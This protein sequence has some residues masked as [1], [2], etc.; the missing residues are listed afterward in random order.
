MKEKQD[1]VNQDGEKSGK[2]LSRRD[3]LKGAAAASAVGVATLG[4]GSCA[5]PPT[6]P[7][8][9][10]TPPEAPEGG[11]SV[12]SAES[13][14][15]MKWKFEEMP[16]EYP[17]PDSRISKTITHDVII[18]GSGM[19]GLCAAVA[20]KEDGADVRVIS[21]GK[22]A[23]SRG[24]SNHAIGSR[25]QKELGIDYGPDT[26]TGRHA[27]KVEK[28]SASCYVDERKWSTWINN[29]GKAMDWMIDKMATKGLKVCLEPGYVDPDGVLT[30][31]PGSHS[32]YNAKQ[33]F[34]MLFGAPLCA[35]AYADIFTDMGGKIDFQTRGLYLIRDDNNTGRVSA[36]V[37]QNLATGEYIKYK[38]KK[39]IVMATGDF[40]KDP[41]MM[42][43]YSP[44]AWARYKNSIDSTKVNYDVELAYNGL[45]AGDGHK[46][47]LWVGAGWQKT[48]PNAPMVNCGAQGP[49]VNSID[50]FWGINLTSD[51]KR[52][53][54]EV[55][56]FSYG[57]VALLQLPD[58]IAF[59]VWD[60]RYAYI[61]KEWETFGC[62]INAENGIRPSTPEALVAGW[63]ANVA[64]GSYWKAGSIEELVDKMGFK[65]EARD[66]AIESIKSYTK[67]AEQGRDEEYHVA[68]SALHPIKTPPFYAA[69][70]QFGIN[71]MTFLCVTG[72]LRTNEYLQV[73][74]DDDSPIEGL[75]NTGIMVGDYYAGTYNF[76]MPG[77]NLGGVCNCLSFVLG[78]RLADQKF[79]FKK[80][81]I[82]RMSTEKD[83][84][85]R[86]DGSALMTLFGETGASEPAY[87]DGSYTGTG[88]GGIGGQ[89]KVVVTVKDGKIANI[90]YSGNETAELGGKA[91]PDLVK[92]AIASN[93]KAVDTVSGAT[94]TSSAFQAAL[95]DALKKA[96]R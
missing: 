55:T 30:V 50:N 11:P 80:G 58:H 96:M 8:Q 84:S 91:L 89:I 22:R 75:F 81:K 76:V 23:I 61:Q 49:T 68:P 88:A 24:G 77:Q 67:Y 51:G 20:A 72:G 59:S 14:Q 52:Y 82:A 60:S 31:P 45:Y 12:L 13:Y 26:E 9:A 16:K 79:R 78:K 3:F 18:I 21:A 65:G 25:K 38:A 41:D 69:R 35:Q 53:H 36:V 95:A 5:T 64:A 87:K 57:A 54:N 7:I 66:N 92:Q 94:K 71:A 6:K 42:A 19:S 62:S 17:I 27:A 93:G 63:E 48:Y 43:K 44:W 32:F 4:L 40:S 85:I 37:A 10:G 29:S 46:M 83:E 28:H 2:G 34:G 1:S 90:T 74:E 70:T 15:N 86:N 33:P 56:N 47:G 73:C 39:A